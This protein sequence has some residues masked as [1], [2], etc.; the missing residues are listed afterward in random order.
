MKFKK[1]KKLNHR[2]GI[3]G[4]EKLIPTPDRVK[5]CPKCMNDVILKKD[6]GKLYY[7]CS[8]FPACKYTEKYEENN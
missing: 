2:F 7:G 1:L 3:E 5:K 4:S 8:N 6:E